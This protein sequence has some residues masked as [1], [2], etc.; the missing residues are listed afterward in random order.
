[1]LRNK[2]YILLAGLGV[3]APLSALAVFNGTSDLISGFYDIVSALIIVATSVALLV[4]IWG[5][6]KYI[7]KAEDEG[8]KENGRRLMVNG[9]I[10]LFVL[11]SIFGIIRWIGGEVGVRT[12]QPA[13]PPPVIN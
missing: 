5:L 10:A 6:V 4:F 7:S 2:I 8:E 9:A 1:M 3:V 12:G 13:I 11:F